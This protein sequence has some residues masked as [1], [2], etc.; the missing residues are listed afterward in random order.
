[1]TSEQLIAWLESKLDAL[2][3]SKLV[4]DAAALRSAYLRAVF[5]KAVEAATE[6]IID[7][8]KAREFDVPDDLASR[9]RAAWEDDKTLSWDQA[10][11]RVA[12]DEEAQE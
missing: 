5:L 1:M 12:G 9:L 11:W 10:I 6:K 3:V 4:P 8:V 7:E 2:K